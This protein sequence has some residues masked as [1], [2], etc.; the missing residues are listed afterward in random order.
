MNKS[1]FINRYF[2]PG[3]S[4][5]LNHLLVVETEKEKLKKTR[6]IVLN[7]AKK[8]CSI[9]TIAEVTGLTET[10]IEMILKWRNTNR[11]WPHCFSDPF[12]SGPL[13]L[14]VL[15]GTTMETIPISN[16]LKIHAVEYRQSMG[17]LYAF[18]TCLDIQNHRKDTN[19]K[20]YWDE[21]T[22]HHIPM[23]LLR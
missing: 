8:D 23:I 15:R 2:Y 17:K 7:M 13:Y 16:N 20:Y 21:V 3:D 14:L 6:K 12:I 18:V 11:V 9:Q 19:K 10:E 22:N 1:I 4:V 5:Y